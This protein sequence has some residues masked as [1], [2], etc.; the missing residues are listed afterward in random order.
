MLSAAL[1]KA[2]VSFNASA[3]LRPLNIGDGSRI[4]SVGFIALVVRY[5]EAI[6]KL[7]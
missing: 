7:E 5:A 3:A 4:E 6:H 1:A 2:R